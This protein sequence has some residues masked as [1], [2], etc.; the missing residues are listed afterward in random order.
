[1]VSFGIFLD[2]MLVFVGVGIVLL[3]LWI[4]SV[5]SSYSA[6]STFCF[7]IGTEQGEVVVWNPEL[8]HACTSHVLS[9]QALSALYSYGVCGFFFFFSSKFIY[10]YIYTNFQY[11]LIFW[12]SVLY[13]CV[14]MRWG[15]E[16]LNLRMPPRR[17][18]ITTPFS[19][20]F[21]Y[22]SRTSVLVVGLFFA[23]LVPFFWKKKK[24][25]PWIDFYYFRMK[26]I[27]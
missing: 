20:F 1:M 21:Q 17:E 11:C 7:C 15:C 3:D 5:L 23:G 22:V 12:C 16:R 10:M 18:N 26:Q 27:C 9:K 24:W 13:R 25:I 14:C 8:N 4:I 6:S 2:S 19:L